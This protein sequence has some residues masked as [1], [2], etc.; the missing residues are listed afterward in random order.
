MARKCGK[1][2]CPTTSYWK[3]W[4]YGIG[5]GGPSPVTPPVNIDLPSIGGSF[6]VGEVLIASQGSWTQFPTGY[7]YQ[8]NRGGVAIS[9]ATSSS[10]TLVSAD[11]NTIIT[12]TVTATNSAG[13]TN[14]TSD[15]TSQI[16][17][18]APINTVAPVLSGIYGIG[19]TLSLTNGTWTGQGT[20]T[21]SYYWERDG[22]LIAGATAN[23]YQVVSADAD[24]VIQGFVI[25]ENAGGMRTAG[26]NMSL[27]IVPVPLNTSPPTITGIPKVNEILTAHSGTW[28]GSPTFTYQWKR[29]GVAISGAT[30]STYTL[31]V[32][33]L[34]VSITVTVTGTNISG[35][36]NATS[37]GTASIT[38]YYDLVGILG[39]S[40]AGDTTASTTYGPNTPTG[41]ALK[42]NGSSWTDVA[43]TDFNNQV[44]V[45]GTSWKQFS[46]THYTTKSR[47]TQLVNGAAGGSEFYPN[48]D[49]NNWYTSGTCYDA[50]KTKMTAA[51]ANTGKSNP[52]VL[53]LWLGTNDIT[54]ATSLAD[55][56][57]GAQSL[58]SRLQA[59]YPGVRIL[60]QS[61]AVDGATT[62]MTTRKFGMKK[63]FR[64]LE[65]SIT[66]VEL[67]ANADS[68]S[69]R[70]YSNAI[71]FTQDG[72][73]AAGDQAARCFDSPFAKQTRVALSQYDSY[74][75]ST[76]ESAWDTFITWC[77]ANN[78]WKTTSL[79]SLAIY[80]SDTHKNLWNDFT[81]MQTPLN[82]NV[83]FNVK[84]SIGIAGGS[85]KY[86]VDNLVQTFG[87][88]NTTTTDYYEG[89]KVHTN[90][91]AGGTAA[92]L[93]ADSTS[94][95]RRRIMQS[96]TPSIIVNTNTSTNMVHTASFTAIPNNAFLGWGRTGTTEEFLRDGAVVQTRTSTIGTPSANGLR[97]GGMTAG[98]T[99]TGKIQCT[100]RLK[101]TGV[102]IAA[103][104]THLA[105]LL[106]ALAV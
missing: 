89:C 37:S 81:N 98:S 3:D 57:T 25:G 60:I 36:A 35:S 65:D 90:S 54:A 105:T 1:E 94:G 2:G 39:E 73:N 52:D 5:G 27:P 22:V 84:E 78:C 83:D 31:V 15:P 55:I 103:F 67:F 93:A 59:D 12:V 32:A 68:Y 76:K 104:Q 97:Y 88:R 41:V 95:T 53:I 9:G 58:I 49:N 13:S 10:Y 64:D 80:V 26:S 72:Y 82:S 74:I 101:H 44:G 6:Q 48:G 99:W 75:G 30:A 42:W 4:L 24:H 7:T 102:D 28:T 20:I 92:E 63:I 91:V 77:I 17:P 70:G 45:Y 106:T 8:W 86:I 62:G 47:G 16:L 14:A 87:L 34:G 96:T 56:T 23:T 21:Y 43:T 11:Y 38:L 85:A 18:A 69:Q 51:L 19:N 29:A 66:E 79:D 40:N 71:H 50:F 46:L 61:T 33:D 100:Y